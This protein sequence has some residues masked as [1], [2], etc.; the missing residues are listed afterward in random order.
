VPVILAGTTAPTEA[1]VESRAV[2][3]PI[4]VVDTV[5]AWPGMKPNEPTMIVDSETMSRIAQDLGSL[6]TDP[7][8]VNEI[9]AK[10]EPEVVFDALDDARLLVEHSR[11]ANAVREAPSLRSLSWTFGFLQAL[12]LLAGSI[13]LV[14]SVLYLQSR[15]QSREVS[16]ALARRMGLSRASHRRAVAAEL[17][18]MLASSVLIGG[19]AALIAAWLVSGEIDPLPGLPPGTL[20]RVPMAVLA[21]APLVLLLVSLVGA[22]SVQRR[23]DKMNVS[24]VMRLAT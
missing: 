6:K 13:A 17:A 9:W 1:T 7:F 2:D 5:T 11:T 8:A 14:G 24:E 20:F 18:A 10:G 4:S 16:Y 23:A 19:V 21:A 22:W 12:G 3:I 15:Q